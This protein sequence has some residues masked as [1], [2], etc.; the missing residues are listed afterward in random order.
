MFYDHKFNEIGG[1][2][3]NREDSDLKSLWSHEQSFFSFK[4]LRI[5]AS[6][7]NVERMKIYLSSRYP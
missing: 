1:L 5:R 3:R 2:E 6:Q 7:T 4:G